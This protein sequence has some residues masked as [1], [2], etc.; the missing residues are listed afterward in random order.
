MLLQ[1][2]IQ[3]CINIINTLLLLLPQNNKPWNVVID[4][5]NAKD[6]SHKTGKKNLEDTGLITA[7]LQAYKSKGTTPPSRL[8]DKIQ[9]Y[10]ANLRNPKT[11][12]DSNKKKSA[13]RKI[14]NL[15]NTG[16][17]PP[18]SSIDQD[19][20]DR[21]RAT[22]KKTNAD[23]SARRKIANLANTGNG[24]P[25]SSTDQDRHDRQRATEKKTNADVSA[26]R[27][28]ANLANTGNGPPLSSTDQD[29]HDRQRATEKKTNADVSACRKI[30]NLA[31]T[32]NGPPLSSTDQDQ[33]DR[34]RATDKKHNAKKQ[35]KGGVGGLLINVRGKCRRVFQL[36]LNQLTAS[37]S[38]ER[39]GSTTLLPSLFCDLLSSER[40]SILMIST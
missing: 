24:P 4:A 13:R 38:S 16:N 20:H 17:G 21:Q 33:H 30:A 37:L 18:L 25:L 11:R 34:Q 40:G 27:K 39:V 26:C 7:V 23:V 32:G 5:W 8:I 2:F 14:A 29:R 12:K 19:R 15:A 36:L 31:N 1:Q 9:G 22:E 10:I 35:N 6:P 3:P 28:I